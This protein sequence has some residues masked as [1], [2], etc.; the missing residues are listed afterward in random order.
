MLV[1]FAQKFKTLDG[2][3]MTRTLDNLEEVDLK[4]V[5]IEALLNADPDPNINTDGPEKVKRYDLVLRINKCD[6]KI[7]VTAEEVTLIKNLIG[8]MF[9]VM[10]VGQAYKF[11]E[12]DAEEK[13]D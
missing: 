5:S 6:G 1:D 8:K 7:K 3:P 2:K 10:V 11:L 13:T 12:G 4:S 9:P